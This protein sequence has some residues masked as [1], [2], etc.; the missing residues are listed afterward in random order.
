MWQVWAEDRD[1]FAVCRELAELRRSF[2]G[3]LIPRSDA[4]FELADTLLCSLRNFAIGPLRLA[5]SANRA[6]I[7]QAAVTRRLTILVIPCA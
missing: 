3:Y 2:T 4:L 7:Q 5:R 6:A 1:Q